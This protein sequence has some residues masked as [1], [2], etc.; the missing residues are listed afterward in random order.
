MGHAPF[1]GILWSVYVPLY[2]AW[3]SVFNRKVLH[4]FSFSPAPAVVSDS[5]S[6]LTAST[7]N[8][9]ASATKWKDFPATA[10]A[11]SLASTA[12]YTCASVLTHPI[13]LIKINMQQERGQRDH[14]HF[15]VVKEAMIKRGFCGLWSGCIHRLCFVVPSGVLLMLTYEVCKRLSIKERA[16]ST[17]GHARGMTI[18]GC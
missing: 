12:A 3:H 1:S 9:S 6:R 4:R 13:Y 10:F 5:H 18:I 16:A 2:R 15:I 14:S 8:I 17:N 7:N 11:S